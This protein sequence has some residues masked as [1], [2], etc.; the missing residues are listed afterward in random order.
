L[1]IV[2][3]VIEKLQEA[4]RPYTQAILDKVFELWNSTNAKSSFMVKACVIQI[5]SSLV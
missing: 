5:I 4:V 3:I 2:S 1:E